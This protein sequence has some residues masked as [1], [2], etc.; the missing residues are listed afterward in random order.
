MPI[1]LLLA[2]RPSDPRDLHAACGS[3]TR[4][5]MYLWSR[6]PTRGRHSAVRQRSRN[7]SKQGRAGHGYLCLHVR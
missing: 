5:L 4:L 3:E 1:T 2:F 7:V 6:Q